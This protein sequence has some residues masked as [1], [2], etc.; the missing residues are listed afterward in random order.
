MVWIRL[1]LSLAS[2]SR[3]S[4]RMERADPRAACLVPSQASSFHK[5]EYLFVFCS[6]VA[7]LRM[8][9]KLF[10]L[11]PFRSLHEY[12]AIDYNVAADPESGMMMEGGM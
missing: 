1:M 5:G 3:P 7:S 8:M 9:L 12:P 6:D 2:R 4:S 11:V 10:A